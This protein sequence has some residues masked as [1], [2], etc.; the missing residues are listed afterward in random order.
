M[1]NSSCRNTK[2]HLRETSNGSTN[3]KQRG[4]RCS[5]LDYDT[6]TLARITMLDTFS[7]GAAYTHSPV[8]GQYLMVNYHVGKKVKIINEL[9]ILSDS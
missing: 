9:S 2:G 5:A 1:K 8:Y 3:C 4:T 6:K 7:T